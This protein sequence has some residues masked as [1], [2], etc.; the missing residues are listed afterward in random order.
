MEWLVSSKGNDYTN[1]GDYNLVV[2]KRKRGWAY[3]IQKK[4][5]LDDDIAKASPVNKYYETKELAKEAVLISL[6]DL[7]RRL[8]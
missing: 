3:R 5:S 7:K 8:Q 4:S 1:I 2:F 6:E